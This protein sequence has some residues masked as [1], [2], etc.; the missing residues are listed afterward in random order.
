VH[1][2]RSLHGNRSLIHQ[3]AER[4]VAARYKG[5]YLGILWSLLT[6]LVMLVI[7]TFVF[8]V[9]F[10]AKWGVGD[11]STLDFGLALFAGLLCFNVFAEVV[12]RAPTLVIAHA[13][14]VKRVVFP[15]EILP[16]MTLYAALIQAGISLLVLLPA[17]AIVH[18]T[19]SQSIWLFPLMLL[20]I[21]ILALGLSWI[22]SALGVF[23]RDVT[24]PVGIA[25]QALMFL[26][27]IFYP[28]TALPSDLGRALIWL[29][30]LVTM[31]ENC[32]RTL[33]WGQYPIWK[34][35]GAGMFVALVV[36]LVGFW[37]FMKA[38]KAFADVL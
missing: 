3:L 32:R 22:L 37:W 27:G 10:K 6:P 21:C 7:Y 24:H 20:P 5:S 35:W 8:S 12:G 33:I 34:W 14:Y 36:V 17:W 11:Q 23:I 4:D 13:N 28:M 26:S 2:V 9:V 30:P 29:N 19:I 31:L 18:H 16:V 15:L 1:I 38:R 25:I